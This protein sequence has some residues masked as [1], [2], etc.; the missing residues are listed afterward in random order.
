MLKSDFAMTDSIFALEGRTVL[1]TGASSGIGRRCA[2]DL[3]SA[4]ASLVLTGRD[5]GRLGDVAAAC[6]G[7]RCVVADVSTE[8]GR[9][10][11]L[12]GFDSVDGAVFAAGIGDKSMLKFASDAHIDSVIQTNLV[13]VMK[14]M[15]DMSK[16]RRLAKGAS[17][18]CIAS[19]AGIVASPAHFAYGTSKAALIGF[20]RDMAVDLAPRGI[21]VNSVSP[22]FVNTP[23][24]EEFMRNEPELCGADEKKYLLGHG[25]PEDVSNAV[26]FLL[27]GA[28]SWITGTNLV[29]DGGY[30]C[31]K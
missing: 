20:C 6:P 30:S 3:A 31:Q 28:S 15:R 17:V 27:S 9:R 8:E 22:G 10:D 4:G 24:N 19:V 21:R 23:M 1:V 25:R 2:L 12:A 11:L 29:V 7:A 5:G 13:S 14:L 26:R 16:Q 18:V